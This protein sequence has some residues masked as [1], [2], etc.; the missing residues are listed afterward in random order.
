MMRKM[1]IKKK[2]KVRRDGFMN[3]LI[4]KFLGKECVI[5]TFEGNRVKGTIEKVEGNWLSIST[6][7]ATQIVNADFIS[8]IR[9]CA[10]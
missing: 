5:Y 4:G 1:L 9:Q 8:R 10:K 3:E 6:T 2:V 7:K